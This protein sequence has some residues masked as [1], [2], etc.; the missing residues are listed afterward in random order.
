MPPSQSSTADPHP[1]AS[2]QWVFAA[3]ACFMCIAILYAEWSTPVV[4]S[5]DHHHYEFDDLLKDSVPR[6]SSSNVNK[7]GVRVPALLPGKPLKP[8]NR[9][10]SMTQVMEVPS[11]GEPTPECRGKKVTVDFADSPAF[12]QDFSHHQNWGSY[13]GIGDLCVIGKTNGQS[14]GRN[15]LVRSGCSGKPNPKFQ[16]A[17]KRDGFLIT[18]YCYEPRYRGN[19]MFA[20]SEGNT[21]RTDLPSNVM[22]MTFTR[23]AD[24]FSPLQTEDHYMRMLKAPAPTLENF[25]SRKPVLFVSSNCRAESYRGANR[26]EIARE[27]M[28]LVPVE[29]FGKCAN[30]MNDQ[31]VPGGHSD[32]S[33]L[34]HMGKYLFVLSVENSRQ[35]DYVTEKFYNPLM[36]G[37]VPL[38]RGAP[39]V[40]EFAPGPNTYVDISEMS[41]QEI[42]DKVKWY[43]DHPLEYLKFFEFKKQPIRAPV[44]GGY[45]RPN[46]LRGVC[47]AAR[48]R[49]FCQK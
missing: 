18:W 1:H 20:R 36:S 21:I 46:E 34:T 48:A 30:N 40:H 13:K 47:D 3:I 4:S 11:A 28:K 41:V 32:A 29:S 33:M 23:D 12:R 45:L 5:A 22:T 24:I 38:Y 6:R 35:K 44:P 39:N 37:S 15:I 14:P 43:L 19:N 8:S 27:L 2:S 16:E 10:S 49:G 9:T 42:A 25:K 17:A 7:G 31:H 26:N